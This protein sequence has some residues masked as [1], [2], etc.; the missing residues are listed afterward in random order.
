MAMIHHG[1]VKLIEECSEVCL[2]A[3]KLLG[4]PELLEDPSSIHPD[5]KTSV[6]TLQ[7]ELGDALAAI[8]F[9]IQSLGLNPIAIIKRREEK[10]NLFYQWDKE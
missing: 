2:D 3:S 7:D 5:G 9:V 8:K 4:F 10:L 6:L 1:L